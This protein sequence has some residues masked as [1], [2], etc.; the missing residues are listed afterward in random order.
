MVPE[1]MRFLGA[2]VGTVVAMVAIATVGTGCG[3][4]GGTLTG[5]GGGATLTRVRLATGCSRN[6][7]IRF[8]CPLP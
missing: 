1:L 5:M 7:S 2:R 3:A 4:G 6:A 8:L